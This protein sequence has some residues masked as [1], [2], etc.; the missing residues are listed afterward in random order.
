MELDDQNT[1][2]NFVH[3]LLNCWQAEISHGES[4]Q[5][6]EMDETLKFRA[7]ILEFPI[8]NT[9]L[10]SSPEPIFKFCEVAQYFP[11]ELFIFLSPSSIQDHI[12]HLLPYFFTLFLCGTCLQHFW[13][14]LDL[15]ILKSVVILQN[16]LR[17]CQ[18]FPQDQ[19]RLCTF[20]RNTTNVMFCPFQ[21]IT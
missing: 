13:V 9:L 3:T 8:T 6:M 7:S 10:L 5:S 20:C 11:S 17:V 2:R 1:F 16:I 14:S 21:C 12:L 4:I 19:V 18:M 15:D